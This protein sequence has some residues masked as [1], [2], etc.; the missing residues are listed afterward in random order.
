VL[1]S[2][3]AFSEGLRYSDLDVA[4]QRYMLLPSITCPELKHSSLSS[5]IEQ[6]AVLSAAAAASSFLSPNMYKLTASVWQHAHS[7]LAHTVLHHGSSLLSLARGQFDACMSRDSPSLEELLRG[8]SSLQTLFPIEV[9]LLL[10]TSLVDLWMLVQVKSTVCLV[11][12][13][14]QRVTSRA[15]A[16][17][18]VLPL[19]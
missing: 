11:T 17:P 12:L 6:H 2:A 15:Y 10:R 4:H 5:F 18:H 8:S 13:H 1:G 3:V 14:S 9:L 7:L 19:S 16:A